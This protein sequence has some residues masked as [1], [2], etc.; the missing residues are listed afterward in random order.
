M[1]ILKPALAA[2]ASAPF[3]L[4]QAQLRQTTEICH[5]AYA[6]A[7][8]NLEYSIVGDIA[9]LASHS[10]L[11]DDPNYQMYVYLDR[12]DSDEYA[13]G[14]GPESLAEIIAQKDGSWGYPLR[15]EFGNYVQD[16]NGNYLYM[17]GSYYG[18]K[19]HGVR[20]YGKANGTIVPLKELGEKNSDDASNLQEF[21]EWALPR[22]KINQQDGTDLK[23]V[24]TL[25]SH[26]GGF[27]GFGS[28]DSAINPNTGFGG[29]RLASTSRKLMM[30]NENVKGA[31]QAALRKSPWISKL[32]L[33]EK[34]I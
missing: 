15:D 10:T 3:V 30:S 17:E 12:H 19:Y 27:A 18:E 31:I 20:Y 11:M 21:V 28:D 34:K 5:L 13:S 26:G 23:V 22:C 1:V 33:F 9:E 7:D 25:S 32:D 24:L 6:M 8:N 29:R 2:M 14:Q 16:S 4:A